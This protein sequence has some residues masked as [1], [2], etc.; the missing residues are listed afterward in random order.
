MPGWLPSCK[1]YSSPLMNLSCRT[2]YFPPNKDIRKQYFGQA[3]LMET[4]FLWNISFFFNLFFHFFKDFIYL[5]MRIHRVERERGRAIG[6]GRSRLPGR[7]LMWDSIQD[8]GIIPWP[9]AD[10]QLLSHPD[11]PYFLESLRVTII[12]QENRKLFWRHRSMNWDH[13]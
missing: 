10:S 9:K 3:L 12:S 2:L 4:C 11:V 6:R 13:L 7:I 1:D 8:P 5:F